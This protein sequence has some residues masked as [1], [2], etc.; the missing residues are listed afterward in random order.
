[1]SNHLYS[2]IEDLDEQTIKEKRKKLTWFQSFLLN[3]GVIDNLKRWKKKIKEIQLEEKEINQN[4]SSQFDLK[5]ETQTNKGTKVIQEFNTT[6]NY[7][8]ISFYYKNK[9]TQYIWT[10]C[11]CLAKDHYPQTDHA[12]EIWLVM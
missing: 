10:C 3:E 11:R 7:G 8:R 6:Y 5:R 9:E 2:P 1:M 12:T 4:N